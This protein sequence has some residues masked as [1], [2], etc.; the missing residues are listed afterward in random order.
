V[1]H[2][3]ATRTDLVHTHLVH[4]DVHGQLA[5]AIARV[6]GASSVH[7]TM[8]GYLRQP[9]RT[10][11]R[12]ATRRATRVI[13]V[14]DY[15]GKLLVDNG[16]VRGDRLRVVKYAID[17]RSWG[18]PSPEERATRRQAFGAP[19][20]TAVVGLVSRLVPGKGIET[21]L[22]AV[23]E[24]VRRL[25]GRGLQVLVAGDGPLRPGLEARAAT[26]PA[27]VRFLGFQPDVRL[28]L[29]ACD[30]SVVPSRAEGFG[31]VALEAM[32]MGLPVAASD[33]SSLPELVN[34]GV[35]GALFEPGSPGGLAD[36]VANCLADGAHMGAAGRARAEREFTLDRM[37]DGVAAVYDEVAGRERGG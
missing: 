14:S 17:T 30:V 27:P 5:A 24:L 15:V 33:T 36:A 34:P 7:N 11:A 4:A 25:E 23:P 31:L 13:A 37:A 26:L 16:F 29:A 19:A 22:D 6:P 12:A 28:V 35:N 18:P 8:A 3:R 1:S 9:A 21:L 10:A 2:I 32:A 20:G